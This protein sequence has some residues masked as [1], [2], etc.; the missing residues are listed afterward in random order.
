MSTDDPVSVEE[1]ASKETSD[2]SSDGTLEIHDSFV[3]RLLK[4]SGRLVWFATR[5]TA[6]IGFI[7]VTV[8]LMLIGLDKLAEYALSTDI[9]QVSLSGQFRN[10]QAGP[11]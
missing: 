7:I 9:S 3:R 11:D 4:S 5:K 8:A 2:T 1:A 6:Y 10:G